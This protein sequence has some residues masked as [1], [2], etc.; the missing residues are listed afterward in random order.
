MIALDTSALMAV[1]LDETDGEACM[2]VLEL[3]IEIV[4]SAATVAEAL[5]VA[6]RRRSVLE[7]SSPTNSN[8]DRAILSQQ[9]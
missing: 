5:I 1:V 2:R 9:D 7:K 4:I 3:E 6:E 8:V